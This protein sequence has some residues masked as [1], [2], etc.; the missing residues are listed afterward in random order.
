MTGYKAKKVVITGATGMIGL[1]LIRKCIEEGIE[2][3]AIVREHSARICR[4]PESPLVKT[5]ECNLDRLRYLDADKL[6]SRGIEPG[7]YDVLYHFAWAATIGSGRNDMRLQTDNISYSLDAVELAALLGCH[8]FVGAGSQ[9][10]YGRCHTK[11]S[12]KTPVFPE[13]GYGMA[14]LCAGQMTRV[15]CQKR[16]IRHIWTRILSVYGPGDGEGTMISSVIRKL[17]EGEKPALTAGEQMWDYLYSEDAARAMYLLGSRGVDGRV[18][19]I[20]SG[21]A[22][23]LKEYVQILRDVIN[24]SL[25]LGFG[26]VPYGERQVMYLC[27]DISALTADTGFLPQ[28]VF[29]EGIRKT[30]EVLKEYTV[31]NGAS[32]EGKNYA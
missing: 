2:V 28:I 24:P 30:I 4:I 12:D 15:E 16:G 1:A 9:A 10:E 25:P 32:I 22:R 27:A 18:Y 29:E 20:G 23:P 21:Q 3:L 14:K 26:E 17:L 8:T 6:K 5:L 31:F 7:G 11:L 19:C 13:N